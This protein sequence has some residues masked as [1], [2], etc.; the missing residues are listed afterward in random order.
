[1]EANEFLLKAIN[2][3]WKPRISYWRPMISFWKPMSSYRI[4]MIF[5][6]E[7]RWVPVENEWFPIENQW[8]PVE[9]Q[10]FSVENVQG[11]DPKCQAL[12]FWLIF[13]FSG[14]GTPWDRFLD[15][16]HVWFRSEG[17]ETFKIGSWGP[18]GT[19]P[20]SQNGKGPEDRAPGRGTG[21]GDWAGAGTV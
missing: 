2:F 7:N 4:P 3:H 12:L 21:P 16:E 17:A 20:P 13:A 15:P 6:I 14:S 10:W 1:M 11:M 9:N 8:F 5:P 18:L 19:S